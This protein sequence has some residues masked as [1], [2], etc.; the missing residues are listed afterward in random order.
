M[1]KGKRLLLILREGKQVNESRIRC[2][3]NSSAVELYKP[4]GFCWV[5]SC[6]ADQTCFTINCN[7]RIFLFFIERSIKPRQLL[8]K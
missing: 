6:F 3:M 2:K 8:E 1:E 5:L 4:A 7:R